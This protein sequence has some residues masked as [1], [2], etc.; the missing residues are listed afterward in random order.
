M[1]GVDLSATSPAGS[2]AKL[3]G[4]A[5]FLH[6]DDPLEVVVYD[7]FGDDPAVASA[8]SILTLEA[9]IRG[10]KLL[11]S[12]VSDPQQLAS[13]AATLQASVV[14]LPAMP[15]GAG[16][17]LTEA[18]QLLATP[19][20][21]FASQG[22]V[23]IG[24]TREPKAAGFVRDLGLFGDLVAHPASPGP[25]VIAAWL[26]AISTGVLSPFAQ[27]PQSL[28]FESPAFLGPDT[29]IVVR[30]SSDEPVVVHRVFSP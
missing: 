10:R 5:A 8:L 2:P 14:I 28:A 22:G 3:L 9:A 17:D 24:L 12:A 25:L 1:M 13:L 27:G 26:D 21:D 29:S 23:V 18:A 16:V 6:P 4:N 11:T 15:S 30:S 19:L 7:D 20:S